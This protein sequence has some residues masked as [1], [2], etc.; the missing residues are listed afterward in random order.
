MSTGKPAA[1]EFFGTFWLVF[2]GTGAAVLAAS[3][4]ATGIG[5]VGVALAFG[6]TVV[7]MAFAVGQIS[8]GQLQPRRDDRPVGRRPLASGQDRRLHRRPGRGRHRGVGRAV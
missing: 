6:L 2:G 5:L 1:T 7:T 4:G 3:L 8:G